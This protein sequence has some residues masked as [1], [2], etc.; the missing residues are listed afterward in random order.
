MEAIKQIK[1]G[2]TVI[3]V[4][5]LLASLGLMRYENWDFFTALYVTIITI[6]TVG[7]GDYVPQTIKGKL[8]T[9]GYI[10]FGAGAMAYTFGSIAGFFIEG[11]FKEIIYL[12]KMKSRLKKMEDHYIICGF[13]KIGKVVAKKFEDANVP[14]VVID[15]DQSIMESPLEQYPHLS[16]VIG[17]A[18]S[19]EILIKAGAHKAKGL[20]TAVNSDADNA[21]ITISAKEINPNIYIVAKADKDSSVDKLIKAGADRAVSPYDIGGLR[22]AELSLKPEILDFVST[23]MDASQDMEIGRYEVSPNSKVVGH[24]LYECKIRQTTGTTI[25]AI[26]KIKEDGSDDIIINPESDVILKEHDILYVF[27]TKEQLRKLKEILL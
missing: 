14:Y 1:I 26:K 10:I 23:L 6:T 11:R 8:I 3:G 5:I 20:I 12:K 9:V 21:F 22:I 16:Y 13:G 24:S 18:S 27:G 15:S 7:Y 4:I 25:L 17:D 19:D 2:I